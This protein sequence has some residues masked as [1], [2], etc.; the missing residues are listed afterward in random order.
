MLCEGRFLLI[1]VFSL[2]VRGI[3]KESIVQ[4]GV[5]RHFRK[6]RGKA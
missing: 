3:R 1:I 5:V 2:L 4:E 6:T